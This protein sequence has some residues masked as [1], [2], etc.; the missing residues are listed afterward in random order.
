MKGRR[1]ILDLSADGLAV[2]GVLDEDV[3]AAVISTRD[4]GTVHRHDDGGICEECLGQLSL[5]VLWLA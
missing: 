1:T 2:G 3:L 4:L 5:V